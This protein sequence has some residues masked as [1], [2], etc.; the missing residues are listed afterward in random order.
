MTNAEPTDHTIAQGRALVQAIETLGTIEL[1]NPFERAVAELFQ[2]AYRRRLIEIIET[3]P[4][5]VVDQIPSAFEHIRE[6]PVALWTGESS[7]VPSH[8]S[9]PVPA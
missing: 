5:W 1:N 2:A 3:A 6:R 4:P 9:T 7:D 8:P